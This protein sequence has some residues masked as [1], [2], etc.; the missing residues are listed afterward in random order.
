L[1]GT[2]PAIYPE[3]III[4]SQ[5]QNYCI[6]DLTRREE[7]RREEKRREEEEPTF[8]WLESQVFVDLSGS[9]CFCPM[10]LLIHFRQLLFLWQ[11]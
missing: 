9:F 7:K 1:S 11:K 5:Q 3:M 2:L 10:M 8:V 6:Y 4:I